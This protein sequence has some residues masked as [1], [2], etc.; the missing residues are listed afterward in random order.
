MYPMPQTLHE[1]EGD[2]EHLIL[3]T[4]PLESWDYRCALPH[5]VYLVLRIESRALWMLGKYSTN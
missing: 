1:A 3:L 5:S 4:P 2:L